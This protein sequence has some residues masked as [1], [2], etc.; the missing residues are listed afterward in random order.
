[1]RDPETR[2]VDSRLGYEDQ[3]NSRENTLVSMFKL[4]SLRNQVIG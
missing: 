4:D 2:I 1:M 3:E